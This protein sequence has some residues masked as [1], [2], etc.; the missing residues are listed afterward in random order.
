MKSRCIE[1][2]KITIHINLCTG[3]PWLPN[4]FDKTH[5]KE[6]TGTTWLIVLLHSFMT[7]MTLFKEH[8]GTSMY[9]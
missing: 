9:V 6:T 3:I 1:I 7:G 8:L 5:F 2:F 4:V